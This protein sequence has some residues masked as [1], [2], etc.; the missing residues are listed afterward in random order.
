MKVDLPAE[1]I[2]NLLNTPHQIYLVN[3]V[4]KSNIGAF[5]SEITFG[6]INPAGITITAVSINITTQDLYCIAKEIVT[7]I[8]S[9]ADEFKAEH[10]KFIAEIS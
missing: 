9:K 2:Q 1:Q 3:N 8:E 4:L 10:S 6:N 5:K 7:A